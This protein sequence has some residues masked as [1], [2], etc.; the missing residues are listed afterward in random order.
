MAQAAQLGG[1]VGGINWHPYINHVCGDAFHVDFVRYAR[2][3]ARM[4]TQA[5]YLIGRFGGISALARALGHRNRSTVQGWKERGV[6]PSRQHAEVLLAG[7]HLSPPIEMSEFFQSRDAKPH[8][9][10]APSEP[11]SAKTAA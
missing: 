6:I 7:S 5:E 8:R 3:L 11:E 10:E 2:I 9:A 4:Q 1:H